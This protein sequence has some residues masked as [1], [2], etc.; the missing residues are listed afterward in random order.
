ML[1]ATSFQVCRLHHY[2]SQY[3]RWIKLWSQMPSSSSALQLRH[4]QCNLHDHH[5]HRFRVT[6]FS[7]REHQIFLDAAIRVQAGSS[8]LQRRT[9]CAARLYYRLS[10]YAKALPQVSFRKILSMLNI[11]PV[12]MFGPEAHTGAVPY[13]L[14]QNSGLLQ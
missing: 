11:R 13:T 10:I 3:I 5:N 8:G 6:F 2:L 4:R 7:G 1:P 9:V 12:Q 14:Q